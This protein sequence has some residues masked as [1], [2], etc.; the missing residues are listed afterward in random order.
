[1]SVLDD[2]SRETIERIEAYEALILKWSK[3]I[4]LVAKSTLTDLRAR[5]ILDSAELFPHLPSESQKVLDIGSGGGLPGLVLA[6]IGKEKLPFTKFQLIES[7]QR[8]AAFLR[9][10]CIQLDL[11]S[12]VIV[13]R[14]ELVEKANADV[15]TARAL[16]PLPKLLGYVHRHLKDDGLALLQKGRGYSEEVA[17]ARELWDFDLEVVPAIGE[18]GSVVLKLKNLKENC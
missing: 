17:L 6:I 5:H 18:L 16:A 3:S 1:M 10:V 4:N 7:D 14:I 13:N 11:T 9:T 12:D 15:V 8:K 2:V